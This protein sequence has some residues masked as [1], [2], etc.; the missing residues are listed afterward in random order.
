MNSKHASRVV[1]VCRP[2]SSSSPRAAHWAAVLPS[3]P[4]PSVQYRFALFSSIRGA[5][6]SLTKSAAVAGFVR[7]SSR[8]FSSERRWKGKP[9]LPGKPTARGSLVPRS[10]AVLRGTPSPSALPTSSP[11]AGERRRKAARLPGG[12]TPPSSVV[13][14]QGWASMTTVHPD[15][16]P[17]APPLLSFVI[18]ALQRFRA[19]CSICT[20]AFL[21]S[22]LC[23]AEAFS[24]LDALTPQAGLSQIAASH[25]VA[26]ARCALPPCCVPTLPLGFAEASPR[27]PSLP[28]VALKTLFSHCAMR[29]QRRAWGLRGDFEQ[30]RGLLHFAPPIYRLE[31]AIRRRFCNVGSVLGPLN[32][33]SPEHVSC[34]VFRVRHEC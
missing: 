9:Q 34:P 4:R 17:R 14:L 16:F 23:G 12:P 7:P 26:A 28:F 5:N 32:G 10:S 31:D 1:N 20:L 15:S 24:H 19:S 29:P 2:S 25:C 11:C 22:P 3:S 33:K 8:R 30:E 27:Q 18:W 6:D 13:A 21:P